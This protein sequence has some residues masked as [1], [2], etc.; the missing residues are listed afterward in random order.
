M[1]KLLKNVCQSLLVLNL[2]VI[3]LFS[4]AQDNLISIYTTVPQN[5]NVCEDLADFSIHII[6]NGS[7]SAENIVLNLGLPQGIK[8]VPSSL[9]GMNEEM[10]TD[11]TYLFTLPVLDEGDILNIQYKASGSCE[12]M[13]ILKNSNT[14]SFMVKNEASVT[15]EIDGNTFQSSESEWSDSYNISYPEIFI[16]SIEKKLYTGLVGETYNRKIIIRNGGNGRLSA[17]TLKAVFS[18]DIEVLS[19]SSGILTQ[20]S[21][22]YSLNLQSSD[23]TSIGNGDEYFDTDETIDITELVKINNC[24]G[25]VYTNY[26]LSWGCDE[27]KC[28]SYIENAK[29][30]VAIGTPTF[31]IPELVSHQ[32]ASYGCDTANVVFR[33][34][35]NATSEELPGASNA[36]NMV[37]HLKNHV[38]STL[39]DV[40]INGISM[41]ELGLVLTGDSIVLDGKL[42]TNPDGTGVGLED[43]D[44]DGFYDDLAANESF[45]YSV[46][47]ILS[48]DE[49]DNCPTNF[50]H[51][52]VATNLSASDKCGSKIK[53]PNNNF[54]YISV[55]GRNEGESIISGPTDL[56]T[57][58]TG[59]FTYNHS[60]RL[61]TPIQ[62]SG[63]T[64]IDHL[65][66][67]S[68]IMRAY[69]TIPTGYEWTG[70]AYL[71]NLPTEAYQT[72]NVIIIEGGSFDGGTDVYNKTFGIDLKVTC[73]APTGTA[74]INWK[75]QSE[76]SPCSAPIPVSCG[77][78]VVQTHNQ[79]CGQDLFSGICLETTSFKVERTTFGW[80][81]RNLTDKVHIETEGLALNRVYQ[82]DSIQMLVSGVVRNESNDVN[83]SQAKIVIRY[84]AP[85]NE[86]VFAF[87]NAKVKIYDALNA[88]Y[89]L[90]DVAAP[91]V[92][93]ENN[94]FEL[95]FDIQNAI[96]EYLPNGLQD[97]DSV[98]LIA[99]FEVRKSSELPDGIYTVPNLRAEHQSVRSDNGETVS[100]DNWGANLTILTVKY[101]TSTFLIN[102]TVRTCNETTMFIQT[103]TSGGLGFN[104]D[105]PNEFRFTEQWGDTI[106]A[107]IPPDFEYVQ[108]SSFFR[109]INGSS[110]SYNQN[111]ADPI[112]DEENNT[113]TFIR[114]HSYDAVWPL[115]DKRGTVYKSI[116]F[117]FKSHG[118]LPSA[119]NLTINAKLDLVEFAHAPDEDAKNYVNDITVDRNFLFRQT[120]VNAQV[121]QATVYAYERNFSWDLRLHNPS[122]IDA[123]NIWMTIQNL[124]ENIIVDSIYDNSNNNF[125]DF[126][127]V[128]GFVIVNS[129]KLIA[130]N[131]KYLQIKGHTV[132]CDGNILDSLIVQTG[133][134]CGAITNLP[135]ESVCAKNKLHL[136]LVPQQSNLQVNVSDSE[137]PDICSPST[138]ELD[139]TSTLQGKVYDITVQL[140][141]PQGASVSSASYLH[142]SDGNWNILPA[143]STTENDGIVGWD[144][145]NIIPSLTNGLSG[146]TD[147]S[148]NKIKLKIELA[149]ACDFDL[150]KAIRF[151]TH[152]TKNCGELI[153][154]TAQ[155]QIKSNDFPVIDTLELSL[156]TNEN[157]ACGE[158]SSFELKIKNTGNF[159]SQSQGYLEF[160]L[161]EG[162]TFVSGS[163]NRTPVEVNQDDASTLIW[164]F[165]NGIAAGDSLIFSGQ[166]E[167]SNAA[168]C[169]PQILE[170]VTYVKS[171]VY[172]SNNCFMTATT[173]KATSTISRKVV[174]A[175]FTVPDLL[176]MRESFTIIP[177]KNT[178]E[179]SY[180]WDFGDGTTSQEQNPTH[181]Y[182]SEY[183]KT[184]TYTVSDECS[185]DTLSKEIFIQNCC[186]NE[187]QNAG[188]CDDCDAYISVKFQDND[189]SCVD[190]ESCKELSNVVLLDCDNNY[191]RFDKLSSKTGKFCHPQGKK[192]VSIW[193]K[194][195]CYLSGEGNGYGRRFDNFCNDCTS[196]EKVAMKGIVSVY[197]NPFRDNIHLD[198]KLRGFEQIEISIFS[199]TGQLLS[200]SSL[201]GNLNRENINLEG[202]SRGVYLLVI[203]SEGKIIHSQRI[204]KSS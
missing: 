93:N 65:D 42:T 18:N 16:E 97:A 175:D 7:V 185:S 110:L 19:V 5:M 74:E 203:Q 130:Q 80:T 89:F 106:V 50:S 47:Y 26:E 152:A 162:I 72:D 178:C 84:E 164:D 160:A 59:T 62:P 202:F 139:I 133:F 102:P 63:N 24:F 143:P 193:V 165:Q 115:A 4:N 25:E 83:L 10:Q 125:L 88:T 187:V 142:H 17:F 145:Q 105:F 71:D 12:I 131:F 153:Q 70:A 180:F 66:C 196:E 191:F 64:Q 99:Y 186:S 51:V 60:Y 141:L 151:T 135:D 57:D 199:A 37:I 174:E 179:S 127:I 137:T 184:V 168:V 11:G 155:K 94:H 32:K 22:G 73:D 90:S 14:T 163:S 111:I 96:D 112:I 198:Y 82:S 149:T 6:Y 123:E 114:S 2:S 1:K 169:K 49:F 146:S 150:S 58:Q 20:T 147:T 29:T 118:C 100:C 108:G 161:P 182:K 190:V 76:C 68:G 77:I 30:L 192:I 107:S 156:T 159:S 15:Y 170:A 21:E 69:V 132:N 31:D 52:F 55:A 201:D 23:F 13:T 86:A 41:N 87:D 28:E 134:S 144:F 44:G 166:L 98:N 117:N 34:K 54:R 177:T 172:C 48:G 40:K 195:G 116:R 194:S 38:V 188:T 56:L 3:T 53:T 140:E 9:T 176:C 189:P 183:S 197:P 154:L 43:L 61:A 122:N 8:Y 113:L 27:T 104:D 36:Y 181:G 128:D 138:F 171:D 67:A 103:S 91:S 75:I 78:Q 167:W 126:D 79:S 157:I 35:N 129:G 85:S 200:K 45:L 148:Q 95:L 109:I 92:N 81:D 46:E 119:D 121:T 136:Y 39:I 101:V 124:S 173:S 204:I 33:A 120:D 158:I